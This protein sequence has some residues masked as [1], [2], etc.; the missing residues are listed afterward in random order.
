MRICQVYAF[1]LSKKHTFMLI[2]VCGTIIMEKMQPGF[3]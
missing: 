1:H 3:N 2:P